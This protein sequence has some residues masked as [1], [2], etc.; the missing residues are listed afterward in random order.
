MEGTSQLPNSALQRKVENFVGGGRRDTG[1][2]RESDFQPINSF[3][4]NPITTSGLNSTSIQK[5]VVQINNRIFHQR[6]W[7]HGP[8]FRPHHRKRQSFDWR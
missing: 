3:G 7:Y 5:S 8:F 4:S 6:G 2:N 1:M